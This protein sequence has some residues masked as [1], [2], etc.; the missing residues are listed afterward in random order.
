M[1]DLVRV[2][3]RITDEVRFGKKEI[4][5]YAFP[6]PRFPPS[7]GQGLMLKFPRKR[8]PGSYLALTVRRRP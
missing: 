4:A 8:F 2:G 5:E 1:G 7:S 3:E 6:P